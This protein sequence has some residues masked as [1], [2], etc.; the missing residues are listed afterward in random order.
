MSI[1][2]CTARVSNIGASMQLRPPPLLPHGL[3]S[4]PGKNWRSPVSGRA[5]AMASAGPE[6]LA[7]FPTGNSGASPP[8]IG[9]CVN[10]ALYDLWFS[11]QRSQVL[12]DKFRGNA[13]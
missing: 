10:F 6:D 1:R 8:A 13:D 4:V 3:N 5:K 2:L 7:L 11:E 12:F 9:A